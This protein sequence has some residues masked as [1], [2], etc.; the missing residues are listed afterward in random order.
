MNSEGSDGFEFDLSGEGEMRQISDAE[1][2]RGK[3]R[4]MEYALICAAELVTTTDVDEMSMLDTLRTMLVYAIQSGLEAMMFAPLDFD[5]IKI[6]GITPGDR[7]GIDAVWREGIPWPI[8]CAIADSHGVDAMRI[9]GDH[10]QENNMRNAAN[11]SL[12]LMA[13]PTLMVGGE[14]EEFPGATAYTLHCVHDGHPCRHH[15]GDLQSAVRHA[16]DGMVRGVLQGVS[17]ITRGDDE[18]MSAQVLQE[19]IDE[20]NSIGSN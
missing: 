1:F 11:S 2:D 16:Y 12:A 3:A 19:R 17:N 5:K 15:F 9:L 14:N 8:V 7:E 20:L 13:A 6:I 18:V 4:F 10:L